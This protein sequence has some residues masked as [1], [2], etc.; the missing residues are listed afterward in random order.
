MPKAIRFDAADYLD[1]EERQVAYIS[2]ALETGIRISC[3]TP[4]GSLRVRVAWARLQG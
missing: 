4:L 2:A 1:T 3:G